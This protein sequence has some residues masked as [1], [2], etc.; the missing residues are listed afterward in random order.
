LFNNQIYGLTK[1]QYSPTSERGKITKS[2]PVGSVDTPFNPISLALGAEASFVAR[3][4]DMDRKH[5]QAMFRRAHEHKGAALVEIFQ[6]CNVFNDGAFAAITKRD[7]RDAMLINLEHGQPIR[8][9]ADNERGLAMGSD[10]IINFVDVADVGEEN[11]LVHDEASPYPSKAFA[12]SRM[13]P[14]PDMPTPIGVFRAVD[15]PEY[16]SEVSRQVDEVTAAQGAG[17]LEGLLRSRAT[18]EVT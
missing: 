14:T 3:T 4:H 16:A 10:G 12:I 6:N 13:A 11:I 9:G 7:K 2:S 17:T 8:F 18:W 15:R 1:G 5:M